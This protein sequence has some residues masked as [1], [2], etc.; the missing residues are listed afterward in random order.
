[1]KLQTSCLYVSVCCSWVEGECKISLVLQV[2][3]LRKCNNKLIDY[4]A[5]RLK[6]HEDTFDPDNIRDFMDLHIQM[7]RSGEHKETFTG[8]SNSGFYNVLVGLSMM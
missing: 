4:V 8:K 6:E 1:M 2:P 5:K 7:K 3:L